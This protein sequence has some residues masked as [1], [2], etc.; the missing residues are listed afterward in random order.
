MNI[1]GHQPL[2]EHHCNIRYS[3]SP[4]ASL[5]NYSK[6][7]QVAQFA[8][9]SIQLT[10]GKPCE[11]TLKLVSRQLKLVSAFREDRF[12]AI[13]S[14]TTRSAQGHDRL[15]PV[16]TRQEK[17]T[18]RTDCSYFSP[19]QATTQRAHDL[20]LTIQGHD[21]LNPVPTGG[22]KRAVRWQMPTALRQKK[23]S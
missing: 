19:Q 3:T 11:H 20:V 14:A 23:R 21:R 7:M 5:F 8:H 22:Q 4:Q 1:S 13:L 12:Q 18:R 9:Q 17:A 16:P 10:F 2:S 15:N 6:P